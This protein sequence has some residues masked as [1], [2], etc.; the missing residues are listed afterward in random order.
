MII[1]LMEYA[2]DYIKNIAKVKAPNATAYA[3]FRMYDY[4][5]IE[6]PELRDR[7]QEMESALM[8]LVGSSW[9]IATINCTGSDLCGYGFKPRGAEYHQNYKI[10]FA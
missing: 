5:P 6:Y 10:I 7:T 9:Y 4:H 2:P 8:G 1:E 3:M